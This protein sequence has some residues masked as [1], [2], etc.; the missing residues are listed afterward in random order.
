VN[1]DEL[2]MIAAGMASLDTASHKAEVAAIREYFYLNGERRRYPDEVDAVKAAQAIIRK[3]TGKPCPKTFSDGLRKRLQ[4]RRAITVERRDAEV[5]QVDMH[6]SQRG[7]LV[8][9]IG[10]RFHEIDVETDTEEEQAKKHALNQEYLRK[11]TAMTIIKAQ[12][13]IGQ[14]LQGSPNEGIP[15]QVAVTEAY[16]TNEVRPTAGLGASEAHIKRFG[17]RITLQP[18]WWIG[19]HQNLH[20][21]L[22]RR[23]ILDVKNRTRGMELLTLDFAKPW[24]D[25]ESLIQMHTIPVLTNDRRVIERHMGDL[26]R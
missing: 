15:V 20:G 3:L 6:R 12:I 24:K 11:V 14:L 26:T 10:I 17:I 25:G 1:I 5:A 8:S 16:G 19:V 4:E 13:L 21:H 23:L 9:S 18:E 7:L 2:D 22:G